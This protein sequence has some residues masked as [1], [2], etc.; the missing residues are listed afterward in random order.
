MRLLDGY[1]S[2]GNGA[3]RFASV[4][5]ENYVREMLTEVYNVKLQ[6][7]GPYEDIW[8][9]YLTQPI[10]LGFTTCTGDLSGHTLKPSFGGDRT[11]L[12]ITQSFC[13]VGFKI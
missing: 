6:I 10:G 4:L 12:V 13:K 5:L 11:Q 7:Y 9:D 3:L 2:G 1:S 8:L